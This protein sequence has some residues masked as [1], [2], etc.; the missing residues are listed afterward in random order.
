MTSL[1]LFFERTSNHLILPLEK[2]KRKAYFDCWNWVGLSP[3]WSQKKKKKK[4]RTKI[5]TFVV[6]SSSQL[7]VGPAGW[8]WY[9]VAGHDSSCV[10]EQL[11]DPEL[12]VDG[13][14]GGWGWAGCWSWWGSCTGW[15][16]V[17]RRVWAVAAPSAKGRVESVWLS[18]GL[19]LP[20]DCLTSSGCEAQWCRGVWLFSGD[21]RSTVAVAF[22]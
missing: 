2:A 3:K 8:G 5:R 9:R 6:I 7:S 14:W 18:Y 17:L 10:S 16:A 22:L 13:A 1:G 21:S 4:N 20:P 19:C 11:G 15:S 12:A